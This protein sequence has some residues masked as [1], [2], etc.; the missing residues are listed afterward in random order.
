MSF[1]AIF[2]YTTRQIIN[3]I[4]DKKRKINNIIKLK[5]KKNFK[6]FV[7]DFE[8]KIFFFHACL[9]FFFSFLFSFHHFFTP[10]IYASII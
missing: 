9:T 2:L 6:K 3:Q 1:R 4:L 7:S 5:V 10:I 8:I